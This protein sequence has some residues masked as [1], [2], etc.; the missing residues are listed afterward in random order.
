MFDTTLRIV[1][2]LAV[3]VSIFFFSSRRRHTRWTGDWS[4]DVCSSDLPADRLAAVRAG[5]RA[6]ATIERRRAGASGWVEE[7]VGAESS[8]PI[9]GHGLRARRF[10][11]PRDHV[12]R[13][14]SLPCPFTWL[15]CCCFPCSLA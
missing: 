1:P 12:Q 6:I 9:R 8:A 7:E 4:S 2:L 14:Y 11:A 10:A 5:V 3:V 13:P 15:C